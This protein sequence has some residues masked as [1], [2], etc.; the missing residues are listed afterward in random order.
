[1]EITDQNASFQSPL[2]QYSGQDGPNVYIEQNKKFVVARTEIV[3]EVKKQLWLARPLIFVILLSFCLQ[4]ISVMFVG[5]LGELPL[6]GASMATSFCTVT[7]ELVGN[8]WECQ[9]PW[10]PYVAS[11]MKA[12][13]NVRH[14][15]THRAMLVLM[16][17]SIPLAIIWANTRSNSDFPSSRWTEII[18]PKRSWKICSGNNSKPFCIWSSSMHDQIFANTKC[19]ISNDVQHW[20]Y[21][22]ASFFL[23]WILVFKT[24]L[25]NV[26]AAISNSIS[27]W[28]NVL[29]LIL[30]RLQRTLQLQYCSR[31]R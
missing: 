31:V 19:C 29:I 15:H 30:L 12:A 16:I 9:L 24:G 23:C 22:F 3:E 2:I 7:D 1:M 27:Y 20:S 4:V 21:Y 14:T 10:I 28:L 11:H 13:P 26:G 17:V 25:G 8:F 6:A 5:H 18:Y